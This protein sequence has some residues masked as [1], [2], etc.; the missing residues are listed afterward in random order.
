MRCM[1]ADMFYHPCSQA[2]RRQV[3]S[4]YITQVQKTKHPK[5][6]CL[7]EYD[8]IASCDQSLLWVSLLL[9]EYH[10]EVKQEKEAVSLN[11]RTVMQ[12]KV[13]V[14]H[15]LHCRTMAHGKKLA[16]GK[17]LNISILDIW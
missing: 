13:K 8:M 11:V 17:V 2:S 7:S 15:P 9:V 12:S 10:M 5:A 16:K 6:G 4:Q 3:T 1:C 14:M